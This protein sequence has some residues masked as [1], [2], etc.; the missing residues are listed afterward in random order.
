MEPINPRGWGICGLLRESDVDYFFKL[1]LCWVANWPDIP[2]LLHRIVIKGVTL[3]IEAIGGM[4][5][6]P[7]C[8]WIYMVETH[9]F[10]ECL[11]INDYLIF[12]FM[13]IQR[14]FKGEFSVIYV[15]KK[16]PCS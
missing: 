10:Y 11:T 16:D 13:S 2:R 3:T 1:S 7:E 5:N 12:E 15:Y 6:S 14:L 9:S 8:W 4:A